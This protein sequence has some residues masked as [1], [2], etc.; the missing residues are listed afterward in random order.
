MNRQYVGARYVPKF[1]DPIEWNQQRSYEAM[2]IVTYL[3]TSYTSKKPV[4]VGTEIGNAEYW[5]ITGNYNAQVEQYRQETVKVANDL[6]SEI[7]NRKNGDNALSTRISRLENRKIIMI[8]DS[9]GVQNDGSVRT[10]YWEFFR[11]ALGLTDGINFFHSFQSGA[12]FGNEEYLYQLQNVSNSITD[13]ESITDIFVCG[14]WNDSD[15]SQSY[16]TDDAFNAGINHFNEY[17]KAN[18]PKARMTLAHISWGNPQHMPAVYSQ[19]KVS[20]QRYGEQSAKGWRI[21][22]GT[23]HIL[24]RYES[25]IWQNDYAHPSQLGQ[26]YLG[27]YLPSAFLSGSCDINYFGI[28]RTIVTANTDFAV[29]GPN[30]R[31]YESLNGNQYNLD[32]VDEITMHSP[33]GATI[34]SD[35]YTPIV[36]FGSDFVFGLVKENSTKITVP[37]RLYG[38]NKWYNGAAVTELVNNLVKIYITVIDANAIAETMTVNYIIMPPLHFSIPFTNC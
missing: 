14:G 5:A 17:I 27:M 7:N 24:H 37:C 23:E 10:F 25:G 16:G 38:N 11:D 32:Y 2:E 20:I 3:G 19:M 22:T 18:Y 8:G 31:C 6:A 26:G 29:E 9:Y 35:A 34:R 28:E 30:K 36:A 33:T 13:K 12:G 1:S 15:K 4:P 21:L